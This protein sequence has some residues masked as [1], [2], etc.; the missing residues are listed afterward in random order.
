MGRQLFY[1]PCPKCRNMY[2]SQVSE[3]TYL[4]I[5]VLQCGNTKCA[6]VCTEEDWNKV[7]LLE[8]LPPKA[9]TKPAKHIKN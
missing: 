8:T 6:F 7:S 1:K 5:P 4:C 3:A 9:A 2:P